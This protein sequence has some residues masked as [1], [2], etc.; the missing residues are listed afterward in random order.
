V[1]RNKFLYNKTNEIDQFPKF[2]PASN[3]TCFRQFLCPSSGV[4]SL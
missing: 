1:H 2:T 3:S 4:Y